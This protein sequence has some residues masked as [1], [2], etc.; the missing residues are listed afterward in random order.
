MALVVLVAFLVVSDLLQ[1]V[2]DGA[3]ETRAEPRRWWQ[4]R[5]S[6]LHK[7]LVNAIPMSAIRIMVVVLQ[8]VVQVRAT[9]DTLKPVCHPSASEM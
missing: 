7:F 4:G 6:S 3:K 9:R 1:V 2:K 8:I 5:L